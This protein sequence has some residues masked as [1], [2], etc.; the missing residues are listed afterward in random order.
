MTFKCR[1]VHLIKVSI[2]VLF[3]WWILEES[4]RL[5]F[6]HVLSLASAE[7]SA[8]EPFLD[9]NLRALITRLLSPQSFSSGLASLE[10]SSP[11]LIIL[12][13]V[14]LQQGSQSNLFSP[15]TSTQNFST[16]VGSNFPRLQGSNSLC[17]LCG[18]SQTPNPQLQ[19]LDSK[20]EPQT[21]NPEPSARPRMQGD[22]PVESGYSPTI[23]PCPQTRNPSSSALRP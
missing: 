1:N 8:G 10:G 17:V 20:P 18:L 19:D 5:R 14:V 2:L 16:C 22:P 7:E 9:E 6:T 3:W 23:D 12:V 15:K 4:E 21:L 11:C 13:L